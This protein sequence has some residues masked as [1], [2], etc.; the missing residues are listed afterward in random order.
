[1]CTKAVDDLLNFLYNN[2]AEI[3]AIKQEET[4]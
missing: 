2:I 3:I 4:P 1:M